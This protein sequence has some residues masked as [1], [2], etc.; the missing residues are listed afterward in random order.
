VELVG[1]TKV[2]RAL[3]MSPDVLQIGNGVSLGGCPEHTGFGV[4]RDSCWSNVDRILVRELLPPGRSS[5]KE[6][7]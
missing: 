2:I 6:V 1:G 5:I 3:T 7:E 4:G